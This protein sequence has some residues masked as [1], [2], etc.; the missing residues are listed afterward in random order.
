MLFRALDEL[1]VDPAR[2]WVEVFGCDLDPVHLAKHPTGPPKDRSSAGP[3]SAGSP[4]RRRNR[5]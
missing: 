5:T 4:Q 2:F 1:G 3:W